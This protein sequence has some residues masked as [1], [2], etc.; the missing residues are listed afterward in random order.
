ML[1]H[2]NIREVLLCP[3]HSPPW[4]AVAIILQDADSRYEAATSVLKMKLRECEAARTAAETRSGQASQLEEIHA[5]RSEIDNLRAHLNAALS[6][7]EQEKCTS[8]DLAV[9]NA[10]VKQKMQLSENAM[11][12]MRIQVAHAEDAAVKAVLDSAELGRLRAEA[13]KYCIEA[14]NSSRDRD[15]LAAECESMRQELFQAKE[16]GRQLQDQNRQLSEEL[17]AAQKRTI[18]KSERLSSAL[19]CMSLDTGDD[20]VRCIIV[21][22]GDVPAVV[23]QMLAMSA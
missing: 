5:M 20:A 10:T 8:H 9:E 6:Q 2:P 3:L 21:N 19:Q 4:R 22:N 15:R 18:E 7:A 13:E 17:H 11:E 12:L 23:D 14:S 16:S 1:L